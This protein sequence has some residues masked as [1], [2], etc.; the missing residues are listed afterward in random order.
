MI[1]PWLHMS[2]HVSFYHQI[3]SKSAIYIVSWIMNFIFTY[4]KF[5]Y[6]SHASFQVCLTVI[7]YEFSFS[8]ISIIPNIMSDQK[9]LKIHIIWLSDK[10]STDILASSCWAE[11]QGRFC[12]HVGN[13]ITSLEGMISNSVHVIVIFYNSFTQRSSH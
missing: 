8:L 12:I 13:F 5:Y 11:S 10:T 9:T 6:H 2:D 4:L 7:C 3:K 1:N